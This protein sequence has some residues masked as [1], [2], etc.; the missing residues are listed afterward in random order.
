MIYLKKMAK[1]ILTII[2]IL[3]ILF[4]PVA[5]CFATITA[6]TNPSH[7]VAELSYE[8]IAINFS[9][10]K[11]EGT[12]PPV[13]HYHLLYWCITPG[14]STGNGVWL[15]QPPG[16][17]GVS[18]LFVGGFEFDTDYRWQ[19][20][21][22]ESMSSGDCV[23]TSEQPFTTDHQ[24]PPPETTDGDNG[25]NGETPDGENGG[26]FLNPI[27]AQSLEEAINN[28]FNFFVY[29]VFVLAPIMI[30][31]A[32][33]LI[34]TSAGKAEQ[35]NKGKTIILWSLVAIAIVLLAKGLP[36]LIRTLVGG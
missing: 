32:A 28:I 9:W 33:F 11:V 23:Y 7:E 5:F 29:L 19:V 30:I 35:L 20:G 4:F 26:T 1:K 6:P 15:P 25:E 31:Y 21:A 16:S 8:Y 18:K 24:P 2:G 34:L 17:G 3:N 36:S 10:D 14:C 13:T 22:C 27:G 12:T